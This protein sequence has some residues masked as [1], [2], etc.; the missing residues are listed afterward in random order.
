MPADSAISVIVRTIRSAAGVFAAGHLGE[1]TQYL[2]FELVDAVLE[3]TRRAERRLRDL[4]SRVGVYF[5]LALGLFPEVGYLRVWGKM[6]AGLAGVGTSRPS[7][8]ALRDLRRRIGPAPLRALFQV[9]AGPLA[10]PRTPG[11]RYR[12]LRTVAFDGCNS[13]KTPDLERNR[14]WLGRIRSGPTTWAGYPTV[15]L[16]AL[17]E[18]GT[19]GLLG[20]VFGPH[21]TD[22]K[23]YA[24]R[25]LPLLTPDM[26]VLADRGFDGNEFLTAVAR[27]GAQFLIRLRAVRRLPVLARLD[28]G[29]FLSKIGGLTIRVID[30]DITVTCADG[31]VI[32]GRYRLVTTL[33]NARRDPATGLVRLY[34]ERWEIESAFYALR[35]TLMNGRVLRSGDPAGLEQE[36]WA[37]LTLCQ[38]LRMAMVTAIESRPGL[39]PDRACFTT[40]LQSARDQVILAAG[41][42]PGDPA[43][44]LGS[45]GNAVLADLLPARRHR[46]S[47]R[48]VKSPVSRYN[49]RPADD[50]RPPTSQNIT[51][52]EIEVHQ[53]QVEPPTARTDSGPTGRLDRL[54]A[55][56]RQDP[57]RAWQTRE[58]A[59]ALDIDVSTSRRSLW[60]QLSRWSRLGL[61]RKAGWGIYTAAPPNPSTLQIAPKPPSRRTRLM[62][63]LRTDPDRVWPRQHLAETLEIPP[64]QRESFYGQ[65]AT[66]T[67][68]GIIKRTSPGHYSLTPNT[69]P[70]D[71]TPELTADPAT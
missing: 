14:G 26:L 20:A 6:T 71:R 50:D 57:H 41:I 46:L 70:T 1:L 39:D 64:A 68:Q 63:L 17:V 16:M 62:A 61:I 10:Q 23:A 19:R 24:S 56:L 28:D 35:H 47:V 29:S 48:K 53:G 42:V 55:L 33:L 37:L 32:R 13:I 69:P 44:L 3:E 51:T 60:V 8:K 38:L 52:L 43:D 66:W 11:V 27:T 5:V 22:E 30:A 9:V 12:H 25:L 65:L 40:A 7:E 36:L 21:D 15:M 4:P 58:I 2:P 67:T 54:L 34:H 49:A 31:S 18:T 45:I 59:T